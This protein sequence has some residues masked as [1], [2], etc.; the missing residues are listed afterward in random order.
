MLLL[1]IE[2]LLE[3]QCTLDGLKGSIFQDFQGQVMFAEGSAQ[4]NSLSLEKFKEI[5][6]NMK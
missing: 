2:V 3:F 1:H 6:G 5:T 4:I